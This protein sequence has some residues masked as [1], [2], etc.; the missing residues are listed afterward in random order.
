MQVGKV[1]AVTLSGTGGV[2]G[3]THV[4]IED[5]LMTKGRTESLVMFLLAGMC[6]EIA[7]TGEASS[8]AGGAVTSDLARST[9]ILA[10]NH[11]SLGFGDGLAYRSSSEDAARLLTLDRVLLGEVEKDLRRLQEATSA[12]VE[13][14]R[15]AVSELAEALLRSRVVSG[16]EVREIVARNASGAPRHG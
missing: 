5:L 8:G 6:A 7:F 11:A 14:N 3:R 1:A 10:A 2:G 12:M 16:D 15:A 13:S 9:E 4:H